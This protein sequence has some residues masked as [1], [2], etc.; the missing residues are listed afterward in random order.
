MHA[1]ISDIHAPAKNGPVDGVYASS[2][3]LYIGDLKSP[4]PIW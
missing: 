1:I 4:K 2:L 3:L